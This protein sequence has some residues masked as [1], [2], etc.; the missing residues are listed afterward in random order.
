[1]VTMPLW[2]R[3]LASRRLSPPAMADAPSLD[4]AAGAP[5]TGD[6]VPQAGPGSKGAT[7]GHGPR[8][9]TR[10][11]PKPLRHAFTVFLVL[12]VI[13]Y[14]GIPALRKARASVSL[15]SHVNVFWMLAGLGLEAGA[16]VAYACL[17]RTVLPSDGPGLWTLVRIDM[18]TLAVSHIL[19]GGTASSSGLGYQ[20]FTS[21]GVRG[22][23]AAFAMATQGIGSAM[24]LNVLLWLALVISIPLD[25]IHKVYVT[26]ALAGVLL[27]GV[28]AALIYL[29][30]KGEDFAARALRAAARPLPFISGDKIEEVV[31][32]IGTR[33][34]F[35][36]SDRVLLRR[37]LIWATANWLFDAASLWAF[38]AAFGH[39]I[40]PIDL[41]VAYGVGNV[42]AAIPITPGGLGLVDAAVPL[43]LVSFGLPGGVAYLAV[44]GWRLVNFWLPIPVGA[45]M[46]VSLRLEHGRGRHRGREAIAQLR[47]ISE[48]ATPV[49]P[50]P[51]TQVPLAD[52]PGVPR[53]G[54]Q[55]AGETAPARQAEG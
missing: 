50:A 10:F 11:V 43:T 14:F 47:T 27:L 46:Y 38:V 34:R 31:R 20:L 4:T 3:A 6:P 15:L 35:L 9:I 30:T 17:T 26:V 28:F 33:L 24:V 45:G 12:F 49:A 25:G 5:P 41:F 19:P 52:P 32:Q 55:G 51:G 7:G 18:S 8:R 2:E 16:L 53:H 39:Y 37:S 1:M 23:D 44:I 36:I 21:R 22:T 42:I 40:S 13:E 48:M 54:G 29:L